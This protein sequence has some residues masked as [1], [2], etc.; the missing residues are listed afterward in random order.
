MRVKKGSW[1]SVKMLDLMPKKSICDID[2]DVYALI[3][4]RFQSFKMGEKMPSLYVSFNPKYEKDFMVLAIKDKFCYMYG[5]IDVDTAKRFLKT[6]PRKISA[7]IQNTLNCQFE[8][9]SL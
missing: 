6:K 9:L 7:P 4:D 3:K 2:D 5:L 8:S 1:V